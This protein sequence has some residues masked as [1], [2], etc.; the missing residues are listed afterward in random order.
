MLGYTHSRLLAFL[1]IL[2]IISICFFPFQLIVLPTL[3]QRFPWISYLLAGY[4][5]LGAL[6]TLWTYFLAV[7]TDPGYVSFEENS[8]MSER[9][10]EE[11]K[12][13]S[14][15]TKSRIKEAQS[16]DLENGP[17][18]IYR[19]NIDKP[20]FCFQCGVVRPVRAHHC[21]TCR[22]CVKRM[23]HHCPWTGN[24]VGVENHRFF[25]QFLFHSSS[26]MLVC[27]PLAAVLFFVFDYSLRDPLD[28]YL[29]AA[30][31]MF[32]SVIGFAIGYL[33]FY[34]ITIGRMNLTTVEDNIKGVRMLVPFSKQTSS[35]NLE[36]IFGKPLNC[37]GLLFPLRRRR[38]WIS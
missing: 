38:E 7:F 15:K 10:I 30:N 28:Y 6:M 16:R 29:I 23:D 36:D 20:S 18:S 24:C 12:E 32:A 2:L 8:Y 21:K 4:L 17:D 14:K 35:A 22:K 34:Q 25:I 26:S 9:Q 19:E 37:A 5:S 31:L 27:F 33:F 1:G 11:I 13:E 3:H